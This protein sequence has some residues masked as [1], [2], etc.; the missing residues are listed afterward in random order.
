MLQPSI[1]VESQAKDDASLLSLYRHFAYARSVNSALADGWP[2]ADE[3]TTGGYDGRVAGWY[4]HSNTDDKVV[5]VLN[6]F[7]SS[8]TTVT[9]WPGENATQESIVVS[10]GKVTV[11]GNVA[12]GTS[13]TIPGYSSVVFAL[14]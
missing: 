8:T 6:N 3:R 9:R 2:E 5:L 13:V 12:D 1:S 10:N 7:S 4:L 14:N 11:S